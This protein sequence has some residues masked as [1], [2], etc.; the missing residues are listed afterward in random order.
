[1]TKPDPREKLNA[2]KEQRCLAAALRAVEGYDP[3]FERNIDDLSI[4]GNATDLGVAIDY[5]QR[6]NQLFQQMVDDPNFRAF[7]M[8][9]AKEGQAEYRNSKDMT[10]LDSQA[11]KTLLYYE[12]AALFVRQPPSNAYRELVALSK[13]MQVWRWLINFVHTNEE[14]EK[15]KSAMSLGR[16]C[17]WDV[18]ALYAVQNAK[19]GAFGKKSL[20]LPFTIH[21]LDPLVELDDWVVP[22]ALAAAKQYTDDPKEL[23][24]ELYTMPFW[25]VYMHEGYRNDPTVKG[26]PL[27]TACQR[28]EQAFAQEGPDYPVWRKEYLGKTSSTR[29]DED[30]KPHIM[31]EDDSHE[32]CEFLVFIEGLEKTLGPGASP[33]PK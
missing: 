17:Q 20:E 1:M 10:C 16:M 9:A 11:I 23:Y 29:F 5:I 31:T 13:K 2:L 21:P 12:Y 24:Q 3:H 18:T 27:E 25:Q 8:A 7:C 19:E 30:G 6:V 26:T 14:V 28:I 33:S 22:A 32:Y 15:C 4:L